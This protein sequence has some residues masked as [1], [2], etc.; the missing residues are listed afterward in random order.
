M[1]LRWFGEGVKLDATL[2]CGPWTRNHKLSPDNRREVRNERSLRNKSLLTSSK[3]ESHW[4]S[5]WS[6]FYLKMCHLWERKHS[7]YEKVVVYS[8]GVWSFAVLSPVFKYW[9]SSQAEHVRLCS[10]AASSLRPCQRWTAFHLLCRLL[11][12]QWCHARTC[13]YI[14]TSACFLHGLEFNASIC[15]ERE[16]DSARRLTITGHG[17]TGAQQTSKKDVWS[18]DIACL[19]FFFWS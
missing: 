18:N 11:C 17:L 15:A 8:C 12:L 2:G 14:G 16:R 13:S 9:L 3:K 4:F 6:T 10:L 5:W 7:L 19:Y 1:P